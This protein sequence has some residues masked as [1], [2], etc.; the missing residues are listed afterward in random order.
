VIPIFCRGFES[1]N[2]PVAHELVVP[3]RPG[4]QRGSQ[5]VR[6]PSTLTAAG[7]ETRPLLSA[8][9]SPRSQRSGLA[10]RVVTRR[11]ADAAAPQ[12]AMVYAAFGGGG[13]GGSQEPLSPEQQQQ[14]FLSRLMLMLGSFVTLCLLLF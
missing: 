3:P 9:A 14:A 2:Q 10:H 8:A 1:E 13:L 7:G 12:N 5:K 11:G 6:S 4:L